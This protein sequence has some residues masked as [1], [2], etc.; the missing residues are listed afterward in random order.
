MPCP[1]LPVVGGLATTLAFAALWVLPGT[2]LAQTH[3]FADWTS[4]ESGTANGSLRGSSISLSGSAVINVPGSTVDGSSTVFS[5]SLFTLPLPTSDAIEFNGY[6]GNSYTLQFGAP[7]S[8]PILHIYSLAS[9]IAFPDGTQLTKLSGED[10]FTVSGSSVSGA[11]SGSADASGSV[12][13]AGTISSI[14]FSA[15]PVYQPSTEDGIL[16]QVGVALPAAPAPTLAARYVV[17]PNPTC[18]GVATVFDASA[19]SPGAGGPIT[20]YRFDYYETNAFGLP[21]LEPTVIASRVADGDVPLPVEPPIGWVELV[22]RQGFHLGARARRGHA[23]RHRCG[24]GKCHDHVDGR[25]RA[26]D[27]RR[28]EGCLSSGQ[29]RPAP[30]DG[31]PSVRGRPGSV[32]PGIC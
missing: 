24:W 5:S 9:T 21:D 1:R 23:H 14:S 31:S 15:T 4:V 11:L 13:I 2:A 32:D 10:S 12:R 17:A 26:G 25:V 22:E 8:D 6:Q 28:I 7:V 16:L 3:E 30:P 27:E 20:G 29:R 19:S 18:V